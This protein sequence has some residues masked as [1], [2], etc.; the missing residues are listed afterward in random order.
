[1]FRLASIIVTGFVCFV[2]V[3]HS[4]QADIVSQ[5]AAD[6]P[7]AWWRFEDGSSSHGSAAADSAGTFHGTYLGDIQHLSGVAGQSA[8]FDGNFDSVSIGSMGATPVEGTIA[9]WMN[10]E[11]LLNW[12]N[13]FTTGPLAGGSGGND[14]I[15]FEEWSDGSFR[16]FTG[17]ATSGHAP[18]FNAVYTN[19]LAI[20]Q[21]HHVAFTWSTATGDV[22]GYFNGQQIFDSNSSGFP[23]TFS[24]VRIGMGFDNSSSRSWLG[25]IDEVAV[26]D[27]RLSSTR[28]AAQFTGVPEPAAGMSVGFIG[29]ILLIRR[30]RRN[31]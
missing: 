17:T 5:I 14:A 4:V 20:N 23:T 28:I 27:K 6:A 19:S 11:A 7:I 8:R 16:V 18:S 13:P 15:R 21:W 25:Q 1:M 2:L 31:I 29:M 3:S 22:T 9:F 26:F 12:R 30:R 10:T 24:D